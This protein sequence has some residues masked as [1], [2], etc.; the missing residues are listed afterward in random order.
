MRK[1]GFTLIELLIVI[2]IIAILAGMLLPALSKVKNNA[3]AISCMSLFGQFGKSVS[4][5]GEDNNGYVV[6]YRN[7]YNTGGTNVK[8]AIGAEPAKWLLRPY[9][10]PKGTASIGKLTKNKT[11]GEMDCPARKFDQSWGNNAEYTYGVNYRLTGLA[12]SSGSGKRGNIPRLLT[13]CVQPSGTSILA[14]CQGDNPQYGTRDRKLW[15]VQHQGRASVTFLDAHA[16]LLKESEKP[17]LESFP[18]YNHKP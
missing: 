6:P 2:A 1:R 14:E 13:Q 12:Y 16:I 17:K 8:F 11:P 9:M 10:K 15:F 3:Y 7:D 4:M 18:F 5:Y